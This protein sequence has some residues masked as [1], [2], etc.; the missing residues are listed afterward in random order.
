MNQNLNAGIPIVGAPKLS[1][2]PPLPDDVIHAYL[3]PMEQLIAQG[4]SYAQPVQV[5]LLVLATALRDLRD[6]RAAVDG[7][8]PVYSEDA[9][10]LLPKQPEPEQAQEQP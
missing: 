6:L 9:Q 8:D 3:Q 10:A 4:A 1:D 5:E 2:A 7:L